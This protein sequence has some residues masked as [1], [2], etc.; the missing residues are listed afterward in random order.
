MKPP[1]HLGTLMATP[2]D[3]HAP[4]RRRPE[5]PA[6]ERRFAAARGRRFEHAIK[7]RRLPGSAPEVARLAMLDGQAA[8]AGNC[9]VAEVG[10]TV[11]AA[12]P[13]S[14]AAP[15]ADPFGLAEPVVTLRAR[16]AAPQAPA[17]APTRLPQPLGAAAPAAS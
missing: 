4:A 1:F 9:L 6:P 10:G 8:P 13:L 2:L 11:V 14:G 15:V 3:P 7:V 12:L 16:A 5:R 17:Q